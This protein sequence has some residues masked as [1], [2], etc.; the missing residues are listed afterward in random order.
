[1]P[2][3]T[4]LFQSV[5]FAFVSILDVGIAS[6]CASFDKLLVVLVVQNGNAKGS[7]LLFSVVKG[8]LAG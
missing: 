4:Q 3:N 8:H 5:Q 7:F 1:M 6:I 2:C